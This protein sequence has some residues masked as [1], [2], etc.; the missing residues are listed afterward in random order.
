MDFVK[1]LM[2][3][4]NLVYLTELAETKYPILDNDTPEDKDMME[5]YRDEFIRAYHKRNNRQFE[6]Y[7]RY[8]MAEYKKIVYAY[9]SNYDVSDPF[10]S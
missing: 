1:S 4:G 3:Q 9:E 2:E 6:M 5:T 7:P 8:K 10:K